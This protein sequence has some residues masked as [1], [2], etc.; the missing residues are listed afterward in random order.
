MKKARLECDVCGKNFTR[1]ENLRR[2]K[3]IHDDSDPK[4][5][6]GLCGKKF[7]RPDYLKKHQKAH[8][9]RLTEEEFKCNSCDQVFS[10]VG[11]LNNHVKLTHP[12]PSTSNKERKRT[13]KKQGIY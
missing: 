5:Q 10:T 11:E 2:H 4:H 8:E 12:K 1:I 6:C 13:Q 3:R 9:K 7:K